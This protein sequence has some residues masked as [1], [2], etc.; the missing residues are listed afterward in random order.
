MSELSCRNLALSTSSSSCTLKIKLAL[1][2]NN[3]SYVQFFFTFVLDLKFKEKKNDIVQYEFRFEK[4]I[5]VI[6]LNIFSHIDISQIP[7]DHG[8]E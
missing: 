8:L 3:T 4:Q 6:L 5:K 7:T 2:T 1:L